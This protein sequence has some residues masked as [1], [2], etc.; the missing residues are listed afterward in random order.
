MSK[1]VSPAV[2]GAFVVGGLAVLI[3]AIMV[4]G[5]GKLFQER[6]TFVCMFAGDLN[7]LKVGAAVKYSGVEIGS[8]A[9]IRLALSPDEGRLKPGFSKEN[10]LPVIITI[11]RSR[12]TRRGGSG[13]QLSEDGFQNALARGL[14]AQLNV[15]SLLTGLLYVALDLHPDTPLTLVLEP[16]GAYREIPTIPTT[17]ESVQKQVMDGLAKLNEIDFRGLVAS[18]DNAADSISDLA[19][20]PNLNAALVGLQQSTVQ[21]DKTLNSIRLTI[22]NINDHVDPLADGLVKNSRELSETLAET[23]ATLADVR[24]FLNPD[25]PT[26]VNLNQALQQLTR[27]TRSLDSFTDYLE[28]NPSSLIRGAYV[29]EKSR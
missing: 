27:T 1:R 8:V 13:V 19:N 7:G 18:F 28:R 11:D 16:G 29:P 10:W 9:D 23:Q 2:I 22:N 5:S 17:L 14:R 25:S 15:E 4:V 24:G 21:L 3:T 20:S 26:V 12:I 6:I